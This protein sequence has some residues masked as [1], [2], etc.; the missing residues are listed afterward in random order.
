MTDTK[1]KISK[2][3]GGSLDFEYAYAQRVRKEAAAVARRWMDCA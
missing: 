2:E 3:T 1:A